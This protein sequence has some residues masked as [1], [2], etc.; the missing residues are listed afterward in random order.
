MEDVLLL[1]LKDS[2]AYTSFWN[3]CILS[4]LHGCIL[5]ELALRGSVE[6]ER[7]GMRWRSLANRKLLCK[8]DHTTGDIFLDQASRHIKDIHPP[9]EVSSWIEYLIVI[10]GIR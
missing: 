10:R 8:S 5:I 6:L 3:D 1:G 2:E 9:E 4:G 7:G